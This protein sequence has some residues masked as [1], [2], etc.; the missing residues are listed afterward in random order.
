M[1]A[2]DRDD[3]T[4]F[5]VRLQDN[6][7]GNRRLIDYQERREDFRQTARR[8]AETRNDHVL[9]PWG[10]APLQSHVDLAQCVSCGEYAYVNPRNT[11]NGPFVYGG[12]VTSVCPDSDREVF[13]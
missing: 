9:E 7:G 5:S 12:A 4:E 1:A 3:L 6:I 10:D 11:P 13:Y 8:I 2:T